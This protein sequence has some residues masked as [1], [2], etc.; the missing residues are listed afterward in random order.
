MAT[1]LNESLAEEGSRTSFYLFPW[2]NRDKS[3]LLLAVSLA[4][5]PQPFLLVK[6]MHKCTHLLNIYVKYI[7]TMQLSS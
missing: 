5:S 7:M 6:Y 2:G 3:S 1:A 4:T